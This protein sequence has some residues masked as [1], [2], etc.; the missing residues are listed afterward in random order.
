MARIYTL[1]ADEETVVEVLQ[2]FGAADSYGALGLQLSGTWV[3]TVAFEGSID[4]G[5]TWFAVLGQPI[6]ADGTLGTAASSATGNDQWVFAVGGLSHFRARVDAYT[7]GAITGA[8]AKSV[9]PEYGG[10]AGGSNRPGSA[11]YG[12]C[13]SA[14]SGSC[15]CRG[16]APCARAADAR[17]TNRGDQ[18]IRAQGH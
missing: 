17:A 5:N 2:G 16:F 8:S 1:R 4:N 10:G 9:A 15:C 6:A 14:G 12:A 3:G 7:S 13:G 18:A 11:R